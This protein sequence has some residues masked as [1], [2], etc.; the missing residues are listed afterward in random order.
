MTT[1]RLTVLQ[2]LGLLVG[3][4]TWAA[5]H[6]VGYGITEAHC[7]VG[8]AR[9]GIGL[10]VWQATLMSVAALVVLAAE[11]AA[12]TVVVRTRGLDDSA[13]PPLGRVHFFGVAAAA[14]NAI[15]LTIILLDGFAAIFDAACRQS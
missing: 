9:W 5:V 1:R 10:D 2:W 4:F 14:A 3:A 15:F 12:V 6:V 7:S 11:A 8:G 13:A